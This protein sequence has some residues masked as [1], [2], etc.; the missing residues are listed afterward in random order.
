MPKT[1]P[2]LYFLKACTIQAIA[3]SR[4]RPHSLTPSQHWQAKKN[5]LADPLCLGVPADHPEKVHSK[6]VSGKITMSPPFQY[7]TTPPKKFIRQTK[8]PG[9]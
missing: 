8:N 9:I 4:F 2:N 3:V 7:S 6:K 1:P 5:P